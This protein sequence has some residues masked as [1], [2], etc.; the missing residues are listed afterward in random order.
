M[1]LSTGSQ[2]TGVDLIVPDIILIIAFSWVSI[3]FVCELLAIL[4]HCIQ[5]PIRRGLVQIS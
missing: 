2:G 4:V 3:L 1:L 5:L